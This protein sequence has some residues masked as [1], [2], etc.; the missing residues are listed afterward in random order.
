MNKIQGNGDALSKL[1]KLT[2]VSLP[3]LALP[4]LLQVA[5]A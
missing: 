5:E 4:A 2:S 1:A 3:L